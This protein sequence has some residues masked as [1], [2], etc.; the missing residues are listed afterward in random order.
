MMFF[1]PFSML[2]GGIGLL[3]CY[4][5]VEMKRG[6]GLIERACAA[7]PHYPSVLHLALALVFFDV[8][9]FEAARR[10]LDALQFRGGLSEPLLRAA[11]AALED[12]FETARREWQ[13]VLAAFPTFPQDGARS[14]GFL[15]H[16]DYLAQIAA[17]MQRA[18]IH[19]ELAE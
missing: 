12:D 15:W 3:L 16:P 14:L 5:K 8:G 11:M 18:G 7:N 19:F 6:V 1:H 9:N 2:L 10:E 17:A 4:Q 13:G